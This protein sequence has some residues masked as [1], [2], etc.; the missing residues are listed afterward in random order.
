MELT[1]NQASP[2]QIAGYFRGLEAGFLAKLWEKVDRS[3][4][5]TKLST[6][7]TNFEA[8]EHGRLVGLVS[9]YTNRVEEGEAYITHVGIIPDFQ[10]GGIA[11]QLLSTALDH[12]RGIGFD[13]VLLEVEAAN[14]KAKGLYLKLG[15]LPVANSPD[16]LSLKFKRHNEN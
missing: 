5:L 11:K 15:F 14:H 4:Y 8:W 10:G 16:I 2:L 1:I 9:V 6:L 12:V 13:H 3:V 7:A